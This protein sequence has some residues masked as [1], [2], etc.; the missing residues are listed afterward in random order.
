MLSENVRGGHDNPL[1]DEEPEK[2]DPA[3]FTKLLMYQ[4]YDKLQL[5]REGRKVSSKTLVRNTQ[6]KT[7]FP[8]DTIIPRH[9]AAVPT[10]ALLNAGQLVRHV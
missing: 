4:A 8:F 7:S 10:C 3:L 6:L 2:E 1:A 5:Q 9:R